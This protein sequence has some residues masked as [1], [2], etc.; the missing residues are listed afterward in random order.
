MR[1][2]LIVV[3]EEFLAKGLALALMDNFQSIHTTKN[4]FTA[5]NIIN[6]ENID[7]VIT[8]ITFDTIESSTYIDKITD[9]SKMDS[10]II[11]L[12]DG[13]FT[14]SHN[15]KKMNFI[16]L[17]KPISVKKILE[18]I[19]MASSKLNINLSGGK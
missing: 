2:L 10:T 4:P 16:I 7:L 6:T 11:I 19:D 1:S 3:K 9:S 17:S 5:L 12:N 8:E 15:E 18:I 14:L 13:T